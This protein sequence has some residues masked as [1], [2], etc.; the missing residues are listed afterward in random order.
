MMQDNTLHAL[1]TSI[2]RLEGRAPQIPPTVTGRST[3]AD[4]D[5][6]WQTGLSAI[7]QHLSGHGLKP[8]GLHDLMTADAACGASTGFAFGLIR[9]R[10]LQAAA[11]MIVWIGCRDDL[12]APGL[13]AWG[14][15]PRHLLQ[16]RCRQ[17]QDVIWCAEEALSEAGV[18]IT[19]AETG[20][21][22]FSVSRRLQLAAADA[23]RPL[24][25]L[26][27]VREQPIAT[28]AETRWLIASAPNQ[29][30]SIAL[31]KCRNG[32]RPHQWHIKRP[33]PFND[34]DSMSCQAVA[35]NQALA[36]RCHTG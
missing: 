19:I 11:A 32:S 28:A 36:T 9:Q 21:L 35:H 18:A 30:W 2:A 24:L 4:T 12:W 22:D 1:R 3:A 13:P 33:P 34:G 26:R 25:L 8:G 31:L 16:V 10:L 7:D 15:N 6:G 23:G 27:S 17:Q 29:H 14:V 5:F 20:A